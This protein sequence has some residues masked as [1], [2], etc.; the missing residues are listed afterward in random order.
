MRPDD[1][2]TSPE[3]AVERHGPGRALDSLRHHRTPNLGTSA[4]N[5]PASNNPATDYRKSGAD[6][7]AY[8]PHRPRTLAYLGA[9]AALSALLVVLLLTL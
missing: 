8:F 4:S 6:T 3:T 9:T 5:N 7:D 1:Q 2:F